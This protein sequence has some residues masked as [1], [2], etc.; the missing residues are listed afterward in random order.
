VAVE[1]QDLGY[2]SPEGCLKDVFTGDS[3]SSDGGDRRKKLYVMY[4]GAGSSPPAGVSSP[5]AGRYFRRSQGSPKPL[6]TNDGGA[7]PSPSGHPTAPTTWRE[8]ACCRSSLPLLSPTC[9]YIM[10]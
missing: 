7:L 8:P 5:Y 9:G 3:D 4:G 2:Q 1:G 6:R 10:C